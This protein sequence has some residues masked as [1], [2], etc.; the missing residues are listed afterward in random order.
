MVVVVDWKDGKVS[1]GT[2]SL[3]GMPRQNSTNKVA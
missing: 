2:I 1:V 3:L